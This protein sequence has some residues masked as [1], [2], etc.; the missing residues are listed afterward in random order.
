MSYCSDT[1]VEAD[2]IY[3]VEQLGLL[4]VIKYFASGSC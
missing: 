3:I 2:I 4:V 1:Y